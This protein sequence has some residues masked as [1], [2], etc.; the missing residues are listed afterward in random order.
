MLNLITLPWK[1]SYCQGQTQYI[2]KKKKKNKV[3]KSTLR[4]S[5]T[6]RVWT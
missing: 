6:Y 4:I 5:D 3:F 2:T 1:M